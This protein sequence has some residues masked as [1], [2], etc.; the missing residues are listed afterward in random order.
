MLDPAHARFKVDLVARQ[1]VQR[2]DQQ[3]VDPLREHVGQ[4]RGAARSASKRHRA[5]HALVRVEAYDRRAG[6]GARLT[7]PALIVDG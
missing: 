6:R 4:Q 5:A 3:Q 7:E 2:F 1:P